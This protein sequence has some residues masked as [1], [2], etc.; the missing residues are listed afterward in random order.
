MPKFM[1]HGSYTAEGSKGLVK[2]GGSGRKAAVQ[3]A[4]EGL[5][6]KLES[7]YFTFG[8]DDVVVIC[9]VPDAITGLAMSM[10]VNS[11]GAVR[12]ST[13]PLLSVEDVDAACK[14]TVNYR[15]AGA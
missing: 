13:T 4:L 5:G 2:E 6:G 11:S 9:E 12:I 7:I 8:S 15:S 1:I 3:K 10:A 14:K